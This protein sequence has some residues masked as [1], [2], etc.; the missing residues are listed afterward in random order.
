ML[1]DFALKWLQNRIEW[2]AKEVGDETEQLLRQI[3][4]DGYSQG[5]PIATIA[6]RITQIPGFADKTRAM[7]IARTEIISAQSQGALEGYKESGRVKKVQF[8]AAMDK[9]TCGY[10]M[11]YHEQIFNLSDEIPIPL[12]PNCR[13]TWLPVVEI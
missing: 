9:R 12:H 11:N 2:A 6:R 8:Y 13:C 4:I 3:L 1:N 7:R 10:C 5:Q